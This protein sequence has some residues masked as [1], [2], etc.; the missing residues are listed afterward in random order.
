MN[1]KAPT[2]MEGPSNE[3]NEAVGE[4][5]PPPFRGNDDA[6]RAGVKQAG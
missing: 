4:A 2:A 1:W 5:T 3:P 6:L